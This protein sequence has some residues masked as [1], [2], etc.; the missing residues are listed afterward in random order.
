MAIRRTGGYAVNYN[1]CL[2]VYYNPIQHAGVS[3]KV[4]LNLL[5]SCV[6]YI[7]LRVFLYCLLILYLKNMQTSNDDG[8][9]N[10]L[11]IS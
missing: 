8:T 5:E 3:I 9:V 2:I 1:Y 10:F 6:N 11:Y 7:S 4:M